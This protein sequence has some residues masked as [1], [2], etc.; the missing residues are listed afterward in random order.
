MLYEPAIQGSYGLVSDGK[1][2]EPGACVHGMRPPEYFPVSYPV[3]TL[4]TRVRGGGIG[5]DLLN[6][7][8]PA[9]GSTLYSDPPSLSTQRTQM[10]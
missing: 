9:V 6:T 10:V 2:S 3:F 4:A 5:I 1:W 7:G 8:F